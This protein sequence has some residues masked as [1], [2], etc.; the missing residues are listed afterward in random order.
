MLAPC[1]SNPCRN[2]GKCNVIGSLFTCTCLPGYI[3]N[4][5]ETNIR[6]CKLKQWNEISL[7]R[8]IYLIILF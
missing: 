2:A 3:G 4:T 6:P 5:C 8:I 1:D 7:F